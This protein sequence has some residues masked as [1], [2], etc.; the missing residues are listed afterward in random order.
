M[1]CDAPPF[2]HKPFMDKR[3]FIAFDLGATSGR[4]ILGT[5]ADGKLTTEEITRFPNAMQEID[6]RL[7]WDIFSLYGHLVEG[8]AAVARM[9]VRPESIGIDTWG[10]DIAFINPSGRISG[11][12]FAYRDS[13]TIGSEERFFDRIMDSESLYRLTG[14]QHLAFNTIFQLNEHRNDFEMTTAETILFLPDALIYLLTGKRVMEY[15]IASTGAI[16]N[17]AT[18]RLIP[19]LVEK[20]GARAGQFMET[21]EPGQTVGK[22]KE[23]V[24]AL[25]GCDRITVK[26]VAEHDT[27]S[28]VA[29]IPAEDR[30]FAYLSS[31]T[32]SL[33]GVETNAPVISDLTIAHNITN[34][35]GV[36]GTV[37]V[38]KNIT[39]MWIVEQCL[40]KWKSEGINHSYPEMVKLAE[41]APAFRSMIDTDDAS[42]VA[43]HDMPEA[44]AEYCRRT[45]QP[46]PENHGQ[47]IRLI[48]ESLALKYRKVL[49]VL[50]I[51][52]DHPIN[53]LHV[54]GGGS[55]NALLNQF[56]ADSL[57]IPVIAGPAEASALGNIMMQT[58][59]KS[60]QELRDIVRDSVETVRFEPGDTAPWEEAYKRF[61][62]L[63]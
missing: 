27:G 40:K 23:S 53:K 56:T 2:T 10:V 13:A 37:R 3:Y 18:H 59:C 15:T 1:R 60:L 11:I 6:G 43:P 44:I 47:Y 55:R 28:A 39:G 48:F 20:A 30:N 9:G 42:F 25:A 14:I 5:L 46:V 7:H 41:E 34:E 36:F 31:G 61:M 8:L 33:M 51:T 24:A 49:D 16:L 4:T 57:G 52:S 54:I 12:P 29:A 32:W 38:L 26:T 19:S 58:G 17:P 22:L 45:G 63:F 21:V 35:G 50:R 62:K